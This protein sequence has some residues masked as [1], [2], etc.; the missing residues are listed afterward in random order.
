MLAQLRQGRA[1]H[2]GL[3]DEIHVGR[4]QAQRARLVLVQV[5]VHF[6]DAHR[7]VP[8][9]LR[10][11]HLR[12]GGDDLLDL[13][14]DLAHLLRVGTDHAE[15]HRVAHGGTHFEARHAHPRFGEVLVDRRHE[16]VTHALA[17]FH[18]PGH[19]HELGVAG[20]RQFRREREVEARRAGAR[21]GREE[22]HVLLLLQ[23]RFHALDL[24]GRGLE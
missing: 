21:V 5:Q 24:F 6:H 18:V 12:A 10:V 16:A 17:R 20:I 13:A 15:L 9:Q 4:R 1:V 23:D 3:R 8:V 19:D 2:E 14:S 11:A 7:V 22:A